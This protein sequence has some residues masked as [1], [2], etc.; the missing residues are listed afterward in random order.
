MDATLDSL[1]SQM[2]TARDFDPH[3]FEGLNM[4]SGTHSKAREG[5]DMAEHVVKQDLCDR[6]A[7]WILDA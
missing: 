1:E 3:N 2:V 5:F 6:I 7:D 4:V